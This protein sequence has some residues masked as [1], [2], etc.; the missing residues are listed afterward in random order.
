MSNE[1]KPIGQLNRAVLSVEDA[2]LIPANTPFTDQSHA[3]VRS[4]FA[5]EHAT[6]SLTCVC[7]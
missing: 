1:E 7:D 4:L 3:H 2:V 6:A 5:G